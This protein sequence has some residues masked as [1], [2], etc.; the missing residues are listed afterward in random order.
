MA[1]LRQLIQF[2]LI[3]DNRQSKS[4]GI[5]IAKLLAIVE[6][7]DNMIMLLL[8][9][10]GSNVNELSRHPEMKYP[11]VFPFELDQ[12]VLR[13]APDINNS[14][15]PHASGQAGINHISQPRLKNI[16]AHDPPA[17]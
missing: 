4:S 10:S 9:R 6:S 13:P 5:V 2:G 8:G 14:F 12:D 16:D 1:Q 15:P 7:G 3:N 11:N 17:P